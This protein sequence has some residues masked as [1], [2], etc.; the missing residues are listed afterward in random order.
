MAAEGPIVTGWYRYTDVWFQVPEVLPL[1]DREPLKAVLAHDALVDPGNPLHIEGVNGASLFIGTFH[2]GEQRLLFSSAQVDY[3]R[4]WLHAMQLTESIIPLPYSECLLTPSELSTVSP[5][6][7][8]DGGALRG[9]VKNIDKNNKRLKGSNPTLLARRDAFERVRKYWATKTGTWFA[10]DFEE[11]ERDHSIITEFGY[12]SIHWENGTKVENC[13]HYTV[14]EYAMYTNGQYSAENR[15]HYNFGKTVEMPKTAFK[16]KVSELI[17]AMH[18]RGPV[19]LVFHDPS[20]DIKTLKKLKAPVDAA[21]FE[22]PEKTPSEGIFII[23]TAVL[24]AALVGQEHN[25]PGLEQMCHHLQIETKYLHNAGNDAYYTL[26]ALH[27]MASGE[28]LDTQREK[29]W[30]KGKQDPTNPTT[31]PGVKVHF[32]AYEEDSDYSDQ[33]GLMGG[34][35]TQ[36]GV[37]RE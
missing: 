30:P 21:V 25:K 17:T 36:T 22:L 5:V 23:D 9:A 35:S 13:G 24:F 27:D 6:T 2:N 18:S 11:W 7:Y 37:L 15:K 20:G 14:K 16:A 1:C 26:N 34:Y 3:V 29:R 32:P 12:S 31:N 10:L 19:F 4:Y 8:A 33:E 28:P